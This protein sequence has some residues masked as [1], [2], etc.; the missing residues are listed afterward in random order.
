MILTKSF[1]NFTRFV[2]QFHREEKLQTK[3]YQSSERSAESSLRLKHRKSSEKE[4]EEETAGRNFMLQFR[5]DVNCC[6]YPVSLTGSS[7]T[8][9]HRYTLLPPQARVRYMVGGIL[10]AHTH[11]N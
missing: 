2:S 11:L 5:P 8:S 1:A 6:L 3:S 7:L 10:F 4:E 9:Y